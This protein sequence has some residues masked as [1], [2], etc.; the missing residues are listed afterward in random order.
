VSLEKTREQLIRLLTEDESRVI[1]LSGKWGTGKTYLWNDVKNK[2]ID[3]KV[4]KALYVSLFGLSTVDQIKRK[5]IESAIP[6]LESHGGI[7]DGIKNLF[8]T[9]VKA[10]SA[11]YKALAAINDLNL[12]LMA[13]AVLQNR[14][15]V[16]DDIERK[17]ERLGIDEVLGFIDE[18][19][20]QHGAR[21]ILV[22]NDDQFSSD[23]DQER[24]WAT[25]REKV[26][27]QEIKLSITAEEAFS[28]AIRLT[29]SKYE[30][31]LK[32]ASIS[33]ELTNIRIIVKIIRLAN[34]ILGGRVLEAAIEARVVPSIVLFSAI[35]FRG[36]N[37]GPNMIFALN[38]GNPEWLGLERDGTDELTEEEKRED[39]WR[40][41]MEELGIH[42]C[43]EFEKIL[44]EFLEAGLFDA[45]KITKVIDGYVAEKQIFEAKETA[46]AFLKRVYWDHRVCND[47]LVTE[48]ATLPTIAGFLDPFLATQLHDELVD[49]PDGGRI[50]QAIIE[51]WIGAF[52][53]RNLTEI[54]GDNP[55][56]RPL[57]PAI[58]A[59]FAATKAQAQASATVLDACMHIIEKGSWGTLQELAMRRAT[60]ADFEI[61]IRTME[62]DELR[63]FMRRMIEMRLQRAKYERHFGT[64]TDRFVEACKNIVSDV[65]S[66]RLACL[67]KRLFV[68]AKLMDEF[69]PQAYPSG[70]MQ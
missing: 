18:Y 63:R 61:A 57:H 43:D 46:S 1:A 13:P 41:L 5:L 52:R 27:D 33:C 69:S 44:V 12:L 53:A 64:A 8:G 56:D 9:G 67:V 31:A 19:S 58:K 70:P 7:L 38:A 36:L 3:D 55:F 23:G 16:I 40:S 50:G 14:V 17:H 47:Q 66:P 22:L 62:I 20:K 29:P 68:S 45:E 6:G 35:Y 30:D 59:E 37:D 60:A 28:I 15:I 65:N 48:A 21:F 39:R 34:R 24:L 54:D 42:S 26:I 10:L 2:S 25:F 11:H 4:K 49:L 32:R 51:G